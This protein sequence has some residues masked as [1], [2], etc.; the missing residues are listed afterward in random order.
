M[1]SPSRGEAVD[2]PALADRIALRVETPLTRFAPAP[3]GWLHLGH[4]VNAVFVWGLA[5]ALG[6]RVLL[7]VEDHDRQRCRPEFEAALLDDLDW[8]GFA[9]DVFPT[10]VFRA[11]ACE[12]RQSERDAA[13]RDV[14]APLV[15]RGLVYGCDCSR[16]QMDAAI[17]SGRCR[18]RHL[19]LIDGV[20]WRVR[21]DRS[22]EC[23]DDGVLGRQRA[24]P[25]DQCGDIL[26]RDRNGHWTYQWA[27]TTDDVLQH[28]TLVIRGRD[29][30]DS[31]S[32]Q[33]YLARLL[34]RVTPPIFAHHPLVMKSPVQKLS[35]SDR[36]TGVR[37]LRASGWEAAQIVGHAAWLAGLQ[38]APLATDASSVERFFRRG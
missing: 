29:L 16:K 24:S 6:G 7:R 13:Y 37:D 27:A 22:E 14:L 28:I 4:I 12:G 21:V 38:R 36:D 10:D 15:A 30:L 31:T 33:I 34:G 3:T 19:P 26:I 32:R 11:G 5:R 8:L 20:G 9:P 18:D 1:F 17:Y 23:F 25:A 35:K 2:G